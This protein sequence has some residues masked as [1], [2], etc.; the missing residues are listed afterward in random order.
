MHNQF[1]KVNIGF[2]LLS[3][4][5]IGLIMML[6]ANYA[7]F[8]HT[9]VLDNGNI[10]TH[11]HPYTSNSSDASEPKHDHSKGELIFLSGL[12]LLLPAYALIA[13][14]HLVFKCI[15][16]IEQKHRNDSPRFLSFFQE[17]APPAYC[18]ISPF[19]P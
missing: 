12:S 4:L 9:H 3:F 19:M 2:K 6:F 13:T 11:A 18:L 7:Y 1:L 15:L 10:I 5:S 16:H 17:R 8:K 14:F